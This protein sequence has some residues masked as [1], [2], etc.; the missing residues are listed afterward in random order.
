MK[1]APVDRKIEPMT[2]NL[3]L[4]VVLW[5][6]APWFSIGCS[7]R[8]LKLLTLHGLLLFMCSYFIK[9]FKLVTCCFSRFWKDIGKAFPSFSATE[10]EYLHQLFIQVHLVIAFVCDALVTSVYMHEPAVLVCTLYMYLW[11][12]TRL[13]IHK[14]KKQEPLWILWEFIW[15]VVCILEQNSSAI[16]M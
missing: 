16:E 10:Q 11:V 2:A 12:K 8:P 1:P 4:S 6:H 5:W 13:I 15:M 7:F 3:N 9:C 14:S